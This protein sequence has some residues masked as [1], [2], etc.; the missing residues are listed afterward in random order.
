M[1]RDAAARYVHMYVHMY[2]YACIHD[3]T[4]AAVA[5]SAGTHLRIYIHT[6]TLCMHIMCVFEDT[7]Y[8]LVVIH[9]HTYIH[10]YIHTYIQ[11]EKKTEKK[12]N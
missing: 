8:A 7:V 12:K 4:Y 9:I 1:T 10:A 5:R 2:I 3:R 6:Y 11:G